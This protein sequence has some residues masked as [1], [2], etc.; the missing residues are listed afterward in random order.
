MVFDRQQLVTGSEHLDQWRQ[1]VASFYFPLEL[2]FANPETFFGE[3]TGASLGS[4]HLS[5]LRSSPASYERHQ[6]QL[7]ASGEEEAYL[8]TIPRISPVDF[9]QLGREVQCGTGGI[10]VERG[11]APYR[12]HYTAGNDLHVLKVARSALAE[13]TS[14]PD[15]YCAQAFDGTRA[16][17]LLFSTMVTQAH[18]VAKEMEVHAASVVG[19]QLLELLAMVLENDPRAVTSASSAVRAAHLQRA[20]AYIRANLTDPALSPETVAAAC[21]ISKRYLHDLF[22]EETE[23]VG[24]RIRQERLIAARDRLETGGAC[25]I[26]YVAYQYGFSDQARFSRLFKAEFG[27]TPSG[28]RNRAQARLQFS[29]SVASHTR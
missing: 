16:L 9:V 13:R 8:I 19:R 3:L 10:L 17:G 12:F 15:R 1:I 26:A 25:S 5:R 18:F 7:G 20:E 2:Q 11:D 4:V 23:T 28:Y 6:H 29:P 22:K 21:S 14:Q 27:Q 24:T